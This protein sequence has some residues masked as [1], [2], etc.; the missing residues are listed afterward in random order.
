MVMSWGV[1]AWSWR[2]VGASWRDLGAALGRLGATFGANLDPRGPPDGPS[3]TQNDH[4]D[5]IWGAML[6]IFASLGSDLSKNSKSQKSKDSTT[7]LL[8]F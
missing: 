2:D 3:W 6:G 1:L 7:F 8:H 4:L 5:A